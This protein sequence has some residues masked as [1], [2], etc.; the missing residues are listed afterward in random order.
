MV[1]ERIFEAFEDIFILKPVFDSVITSGTGLV[2]IFVDSVGEV[3]GTLENVVV[4][5]GKVVGQSK[6]AVICMYIKIFNLR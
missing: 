4:S 5:G 3:A 1:G 2:D 6:F